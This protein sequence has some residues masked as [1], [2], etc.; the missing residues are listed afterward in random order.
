M[1]LHRWNLGSSLS[2]SVFLDMRW[3]DWDLLGW[4]IMSG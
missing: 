2:T 1:S 4:N 3:G